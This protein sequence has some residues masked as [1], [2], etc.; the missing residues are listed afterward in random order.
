[1]LNDYICQQSKNLILDF[2]AYNIRQYE[3][4]D[5]L[6]KICFQSSNKNSHSRLG[7]YCLLEFC[8]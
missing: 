5:L 8:Q 2:L 3:R 7:S 1:M 6:R 4:F